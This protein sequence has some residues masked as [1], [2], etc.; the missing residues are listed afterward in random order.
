MAL[1]DVIR[2]YLVTYPWGIAFDRKN[3]WYTRTIGVEA[4]YCWDRWTGQI[5][6]PYTFLDSNADYICFD[7]KNLWM[8]DIANGMIRC[9]DP[10][11]LALVRSFPSPATNPSGIT[12]DGK[13]LWHID[14]KLDSAKYLLCIDPYTGALIRRINIT[15]WIGSADNDIEDVTFDGKHLWIS[16][17]DD[18]G[19]IPYISCFSLE[20]KTPPSWGAERIIR[21]QLYP[22][23]PFP[24][25]IRGL[26]FDGK[27]LWNTAFDSDNL[28]YYI[29]CRSLE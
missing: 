24:W 6:R 15:V 5:V 14:G 2:Q 10:Y 16:H 20:T 27:Y 4:I 28:L 8:V 22:S 23:L 25:I 13:H 21:V 7:R 26:T 11:T 19:G 3:I 17:D 9:V 29:Q 1:L 12:F 18:L